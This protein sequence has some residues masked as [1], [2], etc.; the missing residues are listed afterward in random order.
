MSAGYPHSATALD[1]VGDMVTFTVVDTA[2]NNRPL[3]HLEIHPDTADE[4]ASD[5]IRLAAKARNA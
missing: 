1:V 2:D 3:M 4:M 5:L